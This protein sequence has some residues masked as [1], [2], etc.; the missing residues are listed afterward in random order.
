MRKAIFI[1]FTTA[2]LSG[3]TSWQSFKDWTN[4]P[5]Q[6]EMKREEA[7][8]KM[9][10]EVFVGNKKENFENAWGSPDYEEVMKNRTYGHYG[11]YQG[12]P[13]VFIFEDNQL[14][15]WQ[16]DQGR[17]QAQENARANRAQRANMILNSMPKQQNCITNY[18]GGTAYTHCN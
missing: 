14:I 6:S 2:F 8:N 11:S 12:E 5:D 17:I 16:I 18:I 9:H 13:T 15:G 4:Q 3:C 10:S 1:I 7:I